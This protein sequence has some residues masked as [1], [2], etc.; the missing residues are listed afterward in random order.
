MDG[1]SFPDP[2]LGDFTAVRA[3]LQAACPVGIAV[4]E[5]RQTRLDVTSYVW[6]V[7]YKHTSG[8]FPNPR[9]FDCSRAKSI[10]QSMCPVGGLVGSVTT[11]TTVSGLCVW[12]VVYKLRKQTCFSSV[13]KSIQQVFHGQT[14]SGDILKSSDTSK[15]II[16]VKREG[17]RIMIPAAHL[18]TD[19]IPEK[20]FVDGIDCT[21]AAVKKT[22]FSRATYAAFI[23][24]RRVKT[25]SWPLQTF[26][27]ATPDAF[28]P[29]RPNEEKKIN[30]IDLPLNITPTT[31]SDT[32]D[33]PQSGLQLEACN[34]SCRRPRPPEV[35]NTGA[36]PIPQTFAQVCKYSK[37]RDPKVLKNVRTY[38][39][40]KAYGL[41]QTV[42]IYPVADSSTYKHHSVTELIML[43]K[44]DN[45]PVGQELYELYLDYARVLGM[46]SSAVA[47]ELLSVRRSL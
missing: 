46:D 29:L 27:A 42:Y 17:R 26:V 11:E 22:R 37:L 38:L 23:A 9:D 20:L 39:A 36:H 30:N 12:L 19:D 24:K 18:L 34:K 10:L 13:K 2:A 31:T 35:V 15:F 4:A 28:P 43:L 45:L 25:S 21:R 8:H 44:S 14:S 5:T 40:L 32:P 3:V 7:T 33:I 1:L 47:Q 41:E 16:R 6:T